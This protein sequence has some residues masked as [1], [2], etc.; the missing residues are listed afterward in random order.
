[1]G[2]WVSR[3]PSMGHSTP[4]C[5]H[6][7]VL[8]V[9]TSPPQHRMTSWISGSPDRITRTAGMFSVNRPSIWQATIASPSPSSRGI[10]RTAARTKT[11]GA[12]ASGGARFPGA[13]TTSRCAFLLPRPRHH[14]G[15]GAVPPADGARAGAPC[16]LGRAARPAGSLCLRPLPRQPPRRPTPLRHVRP[17]ERYLPLRR[18]RADG[19]LRRAPTALMPPPSCRRARARRGA[20][21]C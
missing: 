19:G 11:G 4:T 15:D 17:P 2:A 7:P 8:P 10:S 1:M 18:P 6:G 20:A 14:A 9:G 13:S 5:D 3:C 12:T 16:P 21:S